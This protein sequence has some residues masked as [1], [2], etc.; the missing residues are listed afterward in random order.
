MSWPN[1]SFPEV[2]IYDSLCVLNNIENLI[3]AWAACLQSQLLGG[4]VRG[5]KSLK[6][7]WAKVVRPCL[8]KQN[9]NK[10]TED[11]AQVLECVPRICEAMA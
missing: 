6:S 5:F 4:R 8:K 7:A 1:V 3:Q 2:I 9:K 11:I 10:M